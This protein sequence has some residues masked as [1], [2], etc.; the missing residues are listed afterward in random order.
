MP[1]CPARCL[2]GW[3]HTPRYLWPA[4]LPLCLGHFPSNHES[5][6]NCNCKLLQQAGAPVCPPSTFA[7]QREETH[8]IFPSGGLSR[9][10]SD[11]PIASSPL[12]SDSGL[13]LQLPPVMCPKWANAIML[14]ICLCQMTYMVNIVLG[15]TY[16]L[17]LQHQPLTLTLWQR[18]PEGLTLSVVLTHHLWECRLELTL[19]V[20][21]EPDYEEQ[22][23][24]SLTTRC[25]EYYNSRC[26]ITIIPFFVGKAEG[27]G[28]SAQT[29]ALRKIALSWD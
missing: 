5:I 7:C 22:T 1:G 29:L 14:S 27:F 11:H 3:G 17:S 10:W 8:W 21:K 6:M 24:R 20:N 28:V 23:L 4:N 13:L 9:L 18:S 25:W 19:Y 16:P 15:L 26:W 2:F 12:A